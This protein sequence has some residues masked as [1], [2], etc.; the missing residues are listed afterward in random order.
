MPKTKY[1]I[2]RHL[3][4]HYH[5]AVKLQKQFTVD[6][7]MKSIYTIVDHIVRNPTPIACSGVIIAAIGI[8]RQLGHE[9]NLPWPTHK[10]DMMH[11]KE[12]TMGHVVI[13]GRKTFERLPK[14]EKGKF[15][16]PGRYIFVV[17]GQAGYS[18]PNKPVYHNV[19]VFDRFDIALGMAFCFDSRPMIIGGGEI[20]KQ[21]I[22]S[23]N[24]N[25]AI[26]TIHNREILPDVVDTLWPVDE[27]G[28]WLPAAHWKFKSDSHKQLTV[29]PNV[30]V[31]EYER[32]T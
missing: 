12:A 29:D 13:V 3:M 19:Q 6:A 24:V 31:I 27:P 4:A 8:G 20:Y 9:G 1:E 32:R 5:N 10:E 7:Y 18:V 23:P 14:Q 21:A 26:L 11:F 16:L 17:T 28:E 15:I 2:L 22:H 25:H 30:Y